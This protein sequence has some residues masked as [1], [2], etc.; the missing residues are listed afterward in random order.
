MTSTINQLQPESFGGVFFFIIFTLFLLSLSPL[1]LHCSFI[2]DALEYLLL[3]QFYF[4]SPFFTTWHQSADSTVEHFILIKC[5]YYLFSIDVLTQLL[6]TMQHHPHPST[7]SSLKQIL[8]L[9]SFQVSL[10][11]DSLDFAHICRHCLPVNS[12]FMASAINAMFPQR[13]KE[14]A[15]VFSSLT[16]N[17]DTMSKQHT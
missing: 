8:L 11:F 6:V 2:V 16:S 1:H 13:K 12:N 9:A 7:A 15:V 3:L 14:R 4:L 5:T 10:I 17:I